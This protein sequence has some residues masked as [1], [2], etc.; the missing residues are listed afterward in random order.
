MPF[1]VS[2]GATKAEVLESSPVEIEYYIDAYNLKRERDDEYAWIMG[3]YIESAVFTA[4]EH[5]LAGR[6]ASSKYVEK[7]LFKENSNNKLSEKELQK[8][9]EMFVAKLNLMKANF[10]LEKKREDKKKEVE[11]NA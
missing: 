1:Y 3:M 7:P 8:Q 6:K 2:L 10:E 4:V 5:T 9:R 11:D